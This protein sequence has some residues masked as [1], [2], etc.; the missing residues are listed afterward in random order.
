M[1]YYLDGQQT[2]T[3]IKVFTS[4]YNKIAASKSQ[5]AGG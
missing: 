1:K 5:S 3:V 2:S 4:Q